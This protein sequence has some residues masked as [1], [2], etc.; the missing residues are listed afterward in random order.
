MMEVGSVLSKLINLQRVH[1]FPD[2]MVVE[3]F[4]GDGRT[5]PTASLPAAVAG[6]VTTYH[7]EPISFLDSMRSH[8]RERLLDPSQ[9]L[10]GPRIGPLPQDRTDY[11]REPGWGTI[12]PG[13]RVSTGVVADSGLLSDTVS[14]TTCGFL[15]RK[16]GKRCVSVA[17][18]GFL[19]TGEVYHPGYDGDKIGDVVDRYPELDIAMV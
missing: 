19:Q 13:V 14:S 16:D 3:I 11:L 15:L 12:S 9:Y 18:H 5:Y 2:S 7:H 1:F 4:F 6:L 10:P 17:N 8:T